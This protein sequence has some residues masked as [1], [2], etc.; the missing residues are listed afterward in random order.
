[1]KNSTPTPIVVAGEPM[2]IRYCDKKKNIY[3]KIMEALIK[4]IQSQSVESEIIVVPFN[5][6]VLTNC[7][8]KQKGTAT[9]KEI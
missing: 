3:N 7:V 4:D 6:K 9:G 8:W 5:D 2:Q 1:M